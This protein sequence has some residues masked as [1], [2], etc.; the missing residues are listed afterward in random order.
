MVSH[1]LFLSFG[2]NKGWAGRR[3]WGAKVWGKMEVESI[4]PVVR[5]SEKN[6]EKGWGENVWGEKIENGR[7]L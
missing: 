2:T 1:R 5:R 6:G 7:I 4:K 3:T